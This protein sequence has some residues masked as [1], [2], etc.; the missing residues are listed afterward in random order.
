MRYTTYPLITLPMLSVFDLMQIIQTTE[1]A[2]RFFQRIRWPHGVFC[3]RCGVFG[4]SERHSK[5]MLGFQKYR[6][7]DC[8]AVFSDTN[9]TFLHKK[10]LDARTLFYA[11]YELSFTKG[12]T[13]VELGQKL[14]IPQRKAWTI[15]MLL[16]TQCER[17]IETIA[18]ELV[19]RGVVESDEAYLEKE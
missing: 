9:G 2:V 1:S 15:L 10:Q 13:S 4:R 16:R 17:L 14:G 3:V 8:R 18:E 5:T 19:F 6:C 12:I 7:R 11:L